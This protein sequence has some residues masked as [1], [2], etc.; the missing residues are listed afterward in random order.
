[1]S[2]TV[3]LF[4]I[5]FYHVKTRF[6]YTILYIFIIP[7]LYSCLIYC[8]TMSNLE[9]LCSTHANGNGLSIRFF[10]CT[11]TVYLFNILFYHVENTVYLFTNLV[12][13]SSS[14][15]SDVISTVLL[16]CF[17]L[18]I[19]P[20]IYTRLFFLF[21]LYI[22]AVVRSTEPRKFLHFSLRFC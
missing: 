22:N 15:I 13:F 14:Y 10:H 8:I 17:T 4:I 12:Y 6:I 9:T 20:F 16:C 3:Y 1:M 7:V 5:L 19:V 11:S 21:S 18:S 2:S